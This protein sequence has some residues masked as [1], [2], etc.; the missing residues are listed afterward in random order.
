MS[1]RTHRL[2]RGSWCYTVRIRQA[3]V[4]RAV[5]EPALWVNRISAFSPN[6]YGFRVNVNLMH[7]GHTWA[8]QA[9]R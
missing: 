8:I 3:V 5:S 1:K 2:N 6:T 4:A 7:K 9:F